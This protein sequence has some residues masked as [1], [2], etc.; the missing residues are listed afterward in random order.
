MDELTGSCFVF[1][2]LLAISGHAR[3]EFVLGIDVAGAEGFD[4]LVVDEG[5]LDQGR[6]VDFIQYCYEGGALD[7]CMNAHSKGSVGSATEP[8]MILDVTNFS[9]V[10]GPLVIGLTDTSIW[11]Q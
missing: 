3:A 9:F 4:L 10:G 8:V 6:G 2:A 5:P 1:L 11:G 7:T